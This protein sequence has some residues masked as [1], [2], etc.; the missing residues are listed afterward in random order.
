M[1]GTNEQVCA[2]SHAEADTLA[3]RLRDNLPSGTRLKVERVPA[4]LQI[5]IVGCSSRIAQMRVDGLTSLRGLLV[6]NATAYAGTC[7]DCTIAKPRDEEEDEEDEQ[8]EEPAEAEPDEKRKRLSATLRRV[9]NRL[10]PT[11]F[12]AAELRDAADMIER[13]L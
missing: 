8:R 3:A 9:A 4:G 5:D 13:G 1:N 10:S 7:F 11:G 12:E 2:F 6:F